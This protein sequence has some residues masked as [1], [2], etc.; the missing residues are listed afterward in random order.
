MRPCIYVC[1]QSW[2]H[3]STS[4]ASPSGHRNARKACPPIDIQ[5][6]HALYCY[7]LSVPPCV[8]IADIARLLPSLDVVAVSQAP[9]PESNPIFTTPHFHGPHNPRIL[10]SQTSVCATLPLPQN[11]GFA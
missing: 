11:C 3:S 7:F 4:G 10:A 2:L 6:I 1:G 5:D 8:R 9:F